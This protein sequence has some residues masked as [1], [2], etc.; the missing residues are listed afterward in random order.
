[1]ISFEQA[2]TA[3]EP[4][5]HQCS[6]TGDILVLG[7]GRTYFY[8]ADSGIDIRLLSEG[9]EVKLGLREDFDKAG[10]S[11]SRIS[12]TNTAE[13]FFRIT[14]LSLWREPPE[15]E[16]HLDHWLN[17]LSLAMMKYHH[18]SL[19]PILELALEAVPDGHED[20]PEGQAFYKA[21]RMDPATVL[22]LL[23]RAFQPEDLLDAADLQAAAQM[24][25]NEIECYGEITDSQLY[26]EREERD[27]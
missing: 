7:K 23:E 17:R 13:Y 21:Q 27:E 2:K 18:T 1:V 6:K 16:L 20:G 12:D 24:I 22:A 8:D 4:S 25:L 15:P 11:W 10:T 19:M 3:D 26:R 5:A 9:E 14:L